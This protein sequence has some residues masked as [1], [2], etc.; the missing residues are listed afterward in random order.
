MSFRGP[1]LTYKI[2]R[3]TINNRTGDNYAI[4]IPRVIAEK[5]LN[6]NF[7]LEVSGDAIMFKSGCKVLTADLIDEQSKKVLVGGG[8]LIFN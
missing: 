8:T 7:L 3:T 2:R 5:F 1:A 6:L 4:T